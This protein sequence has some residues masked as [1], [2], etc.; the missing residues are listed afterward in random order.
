MKYLL[1]VRPKWVPKLKNGQNLLKFGTLD[2]KIRSK[3]SKRAKFT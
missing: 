2:P 3:N 1:P